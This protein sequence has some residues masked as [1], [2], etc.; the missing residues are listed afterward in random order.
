MT[1]NADHEDCRVVGVVTQRTFVDFDWD[2][3]EFVP[4]WTTE[5]LLEHE[6]ESIKCFDHNVELTP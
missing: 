1:T 5:E 3:D 6:T 4:N 2:V